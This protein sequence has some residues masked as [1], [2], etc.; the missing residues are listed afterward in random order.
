MALFQNENS[1]VIVLQE[2]NA[3]EVQTA[4]YALKVKGDANE[5]NKAGVGQCK[6][7]KWKAERKNETER[8]SGKASYA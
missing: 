6:V 1:W 4:A 2:S 3:D 8:S 7:R 5:I